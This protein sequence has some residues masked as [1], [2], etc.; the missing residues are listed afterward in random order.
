MSRVVSKWILHYM[1]QRITLQDWLHIA[2]AVSKKL[3]RDRGV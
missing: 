3:A 2:A 1:S